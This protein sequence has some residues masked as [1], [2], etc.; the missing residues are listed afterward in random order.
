MIFSKSKQHSAA[1]TSN[2]DKINSCYRALLPL[3][4]LLTGLSAPLTAQEATGQL[5]YCKGG[6]SASFK[7]ASYDSPAPGRSPQ[8]GTSLSVFF[9]KAATLGELN[10]GECTWQDRLIRKSEPSRLFM[11]DRNALFSVT[12][13]PA[14]PALPYIEIVNNQPDNTESK[15]HL[16]RNIISAINGGEMFRIHVEQASTPDNID[17]F[18]ILDISP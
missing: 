9:T 17:Y 3:I 8:A 5:L 7:L 18:Q 12:V 2:S 13:N 1:I 16:I 14:Y 10:P 4:L 6:G 11:V 15:V